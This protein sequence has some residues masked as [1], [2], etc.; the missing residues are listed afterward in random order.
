MYSC[1]IDRD[2]IVIKQEFAIGFILSLISLYIHW[3]FCKSKCPYCDF[4]SHV[5]D[6]IDQESM[7]AAYKT[8]IDYFDKILSTKTIDTIFLVEEHHP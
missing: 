3:P 6:S 7:I 8:E 1:L 4:N 5:R 2:M